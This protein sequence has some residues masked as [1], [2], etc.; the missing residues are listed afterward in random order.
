MERI[1]NNTIINIF[2]NRDTI[3]AQM[4]N[5]WRENSE[6]NTIINIFPN[7]DTIVSQMENKWKTNGEKIVKII[8]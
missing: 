6:N 7:R 4:E 1:E 5:K 8:L 3:V 2:P